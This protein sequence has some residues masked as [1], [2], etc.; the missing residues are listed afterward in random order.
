MLG[1]AMSSAFFQ[2][3]LVMSQ[4]KLEVKDEKHSTR[5]GHNR[6]DL[7]LKSIVR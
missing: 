7:A 3:R 2:K 4:E 5:K 1:S 6:K